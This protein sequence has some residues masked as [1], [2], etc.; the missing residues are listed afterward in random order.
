MWCALGS[1]SMRYL[2]ANTARKSVSLKQRKDTKPGTGPERG[3][4]RGSVELSPVVVLAALGPRDGDG[5]ER[6]ED[7]RVQVSD[8][9][10]PTDSA[11]CQH[12]ESQGTRENR[13]VW[14]REGR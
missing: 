10:L 1:S 11:A 4:T 8:Q 2:P 13:G 6:G 3:A 9:N 14:R 7:Q 5:Y 12:R